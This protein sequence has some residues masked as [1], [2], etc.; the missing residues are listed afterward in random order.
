MKRLRFFSRLLF[1]VVFLLFLV[2]IVC[3]DQFWLTRYI[4]YTPAMVYAPVLCFLLLLS[5][6]RWKFWVPCSLILMILS[7]HSLSI[8]QPFL[9]KSRESRESV[10]SDASSVLL[11]N[12][13]SYSYGEEAVVDRIKDLSPDIL[14]LVEGTFAG[15][16]PDKVKRALGSEYFWAVGTRLSIASTYPILESQQIYQDQ[17]ILLFEATLNVDGKRVSF[18]LVDIQPPYRRDDRVVFDRLWSTIKIQ[19][20][21][22]VVLGDMNTPRGSYHL[23]RA[24]RKLQDASLTSSEKTYLATWPTF[25]VSVLQLDYVFY[26]ED[27]EI[28]SFSV[29]DGGESDHKPIEFWFAL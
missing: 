10:S 23:K 25:P 8:E 13:R 12:V 16:A 11:W 5:W 4:F 9:F 29:L 7:V 27:L 20:G 18:L 24:T 22:I 26:N 6:M 3:R 21:P 15:R 14:C 17:G 19:E 1:F 2:K 28:V